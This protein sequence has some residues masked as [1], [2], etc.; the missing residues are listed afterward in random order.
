MTG[1]ALLLLLLLL[2]LAG[3]EDGGGN[4]GEGGR[5]SGGRRKGEGGQRVRKGGR[6]GVEGS[7]AEEGI[8]E[9][10]G[11]FFFCKFGSIWYRQLSTG[12]SLAPSHR[13]SQHIWPM[14][15]MET[16]P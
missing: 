15:E 11:T 14:G 5:R 10:R 2:S 12:P 7:G 6:G 3:G 16:W 4:E 8:K 1:P 13:Q 9:A